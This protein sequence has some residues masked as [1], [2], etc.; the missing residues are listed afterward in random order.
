MNKRPLIFGE[1]LFDCF[2]DGSKVLGGAPFNVAWHLQALGLNPI[3]ISR[4]GNDANGIALRETM[5]KWNMSTDFIQSD[6]V[7]PTGIV[8]VQFSKGEPTYDIVK[9]SAWD[10]IDYDEAMKTLTSHEFGVPYLYHGSLAL[11]NSTSH[12]T[13]KTIQSRLE[14]EA[15][16][17]S[18][19]IFLDIN[20]RPPH[21]SEAL[22][23]E[24][25][26]NANHVK[27]NDDEL[28]EIFEIISNN[29]AIQ[30]PHKSDSL[31]QSTMVNFIINQYSLKSLLLTKG[32]DGATLYT[33]LGSSFSIR[34]EGVI[35]VLDTVGAGDGFTSIVIFGNLMGWSDELTLFRAQAFAAKI[36]GQRGATTTDKGFYSSFIKE[37]KL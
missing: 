31:N 21:Y 20:L 17:S 36:V 22:I 24:L 34:P 7:H 25:L 28:S 27:L 33:E 3:L 23:I 35:E 2:P 9:N 6:N 16:N 8:N 29:T 10:F 19:T 12:E 18:N 1:V 30:T 32:S 26:E 37:W 15:E 14:E 13:L 4:V 11:R 5:E